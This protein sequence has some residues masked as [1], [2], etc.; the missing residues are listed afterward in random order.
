MFGSMEE[1]GEIISF[2]IWLKVE[3]KRR[4]E[5]RNVYLTNLLF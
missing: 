5:K 2:F 1:W 4:E 3:V